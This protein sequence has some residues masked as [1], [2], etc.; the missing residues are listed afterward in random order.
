MTSTNYLQ[1]VYTSKIGV[2]P[3]WKGKRVFLTILNVPVSKTE[4]D[5]TFTFFFN[6]RPQTSI[7]I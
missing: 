1:Y 5:S 4:R 3:K 2:G 6:T 7:L